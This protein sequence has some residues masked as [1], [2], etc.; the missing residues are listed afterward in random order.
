MSSRGM[1]CP[2]VSR[3]WKKQCKRTFM[4]K[5]PHC[6]TV[7]ERVFIEYKWYQTVIGKEDRKQDGRKISN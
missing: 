4:H 7:K 3:R 1:N 5:G 6:C 2:A